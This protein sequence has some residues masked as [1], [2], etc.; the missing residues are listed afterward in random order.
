[1]PYQPNDFVNPNQRGVELPPGCKDLN[2]LLQQQKGAQKARPIFPLQ[3][4][5]LKDIPSQVQAVYMENYDMSLV[6]IIR[7]ANAILCV[8]NSPGGP[9]LTFLLK[10]QRPGLATIVHGLFGNTGFHEEIVDGV[11]R[12]TIPLPHL[13]L[14]AAQIVERVIR[15]CGVAENADLLFHFVTR[16]EL[17]V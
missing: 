5:S 14:E 11:K 15:G 3:R 9:K 12:V 17:R 2:E 10:N 4:G 8:Q 16:A 6:V 7:A 13:W 1:M